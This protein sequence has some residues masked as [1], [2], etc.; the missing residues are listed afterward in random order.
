MNRYQLRD[1]THQ[2]LPEW[3]DPGQSSKAIET[4]TLLESLGRNAAAVEEQAREIREQKQLRLK[5]LQLV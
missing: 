3:K 2:H 5:V 4:T 1:Y